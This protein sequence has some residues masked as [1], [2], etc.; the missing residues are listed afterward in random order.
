MP[1]P[2][3]QKIRGKDER[4]RITLEVWSA[5]VRGLSISEIGRLKNLPESTVWTFLEEAKRLNR[6]ELSHLSQEEI[7]RQ[8]WLEGKERIKNFWLIFSAHRDD[9]AIQ[10]RCLEGI[11]AESERMIKTGQSLGLIRK[12]PET[13]SIQLVSEVI[14]YGILDTIPDAGMRSRLAAALG[15]RLAALGVGGD[16]RGQSPL[17][18][19]GGR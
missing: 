7:K 15:K 17:P 2:K 16:S 6:F 19:S 18:G 10:L 4:R 9:P 3:G 13:I 1:L 14:T 12:E 5:R 11:G 8:F